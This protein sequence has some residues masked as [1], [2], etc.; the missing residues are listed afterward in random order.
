MRRFCRN[1][2]LA[3]ALAIVPSILHAQAP[4]ITPNGDPSV[5]DDTIY[6]LYVDSIAYPHQST[7]VLLDDGVVQVERD[8]RT[9]TTYRQV[10]QVLRERAVAGHREQ[11]FGYDG[12]RQRFRLN[13][14]RVLSTDGRVISEKPSQ[15]QES[16]VPAAMDVP[17][18][19][20]AK[21]VRASLSGVAPGTLVDVSYTIDTRTTDRTGDFFTS[22]SVT[23]GTTV[24]RSRFLV[25]APADM[26]LTISERHL[27]FPRKEEVRHGR[28][29]YTWAT[30][31]VKWVKPEQ[32][33][34]DTA[35]QTQWISLSSPGH[36][37]DVASWYETLAHD[38]EL[39]PEALRDT[40]R[41]LVAHAKT[42]DDSIRA[43]HRWVAQDIRY[44]AIELGRGGYQPRQPATVMQTGFGDCKDK[45]T[46]FVASLRAMGID[47]YPVLLNAGGLV[48]PAL[49]TIKAFNHEIAAVALPGKAGYQYVDLT[50]ELNPYGTIPYPDAGEFGLLVRPDG[51]SEEVRIPADAP[52]SDRFALLQTSVLANDGSISGWF[53]QRGT[54]LAE[55]GL[56]QE[57]R[58]PMDST[59][60]AEFM[61]QMAA[62]VYPDAKGDSL[63]VFDGKDL[64][65][66]PRVAV[67][68]H[69]GQ[70]ATRSG[71]TA[72]LTLGVS[73]G[74]APFDRIADELTAA[75]DRELAIDAKR[76]VGPLTIIGVTRITLPDGWHVHLP[77][78]DSAS[79]VFGT[80][81]ARYKQDGRDFVVQRQISGGTGI[82]P[83]EKVG[84]LI[85]WMHAVG[86]DRTP[87]VVVDTQ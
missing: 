5:A 24:K 32:F 61:R 79:S 77:P 19:Q 52:G 76:V 60:R 15:M 39:A 74:T 53:E 45:A 87:F 20:H 16:D 75:G 63:V 44:V 8:G 86:K 36:W 66:T 35:E 37:S 10:V 23:A 85:A 34:P 58:S 29:I 82:Y 67:H 78:N 56:R 33:A 27:T 22:W 84:D 62:N 43:I 71:N 2:V 73:A 3:L 83:P 69:G 21:V 31:D 26:P 81:V 6:K 49:T 47:A 72:I 40:V 38:R 30:K 55:Q 1:P 64:S 12:D 41:R 80:Y 14:A 65:A 57:M 13:W 70:A 28:R 18:Y 51:H 17:T 59:R 9:S 7:V 68:F 11:E 50:S 42:R 4:T 25:D 46:L 48:D 54:G